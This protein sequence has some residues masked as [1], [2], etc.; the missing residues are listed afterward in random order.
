[1]KDL[2]ICG[3]QNIIRKLILNLIQWFL[4]LVKCAMHISLDIFL[5]CDIF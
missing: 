5:V 2:E 1:M 4:N 3:Y